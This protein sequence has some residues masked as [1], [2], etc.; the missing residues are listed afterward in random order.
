MSISEHN[1]AGSAAHS[2]R[3]LGGEIG[4]I[5]RVWVPLLFL[6]VTFYFGTQIA[7]GLCFI[8]PFGVRLNAAAVY[9]VLATTFLSWLLYRQRAWGRTRGGEPYSDAD[10]VV[11][12]VQIALWML[13]VGAGSLVLPI[14][15]Q[16]KPWSTWSLVFLYSGFAVTGFVKRKRLALAAKTQFE[17]I[18]IS[19]TRSRGMNTNS[20]GHES[21]TPEP[22]RPSPLD[23]AIPLDSA[24]AHV[25]GSDP[26]PE[27]GESGF[28]QEKFNG[29]SAESGGHL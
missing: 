11:A 21:T 15:L 27:F 13:L 22:D 25:W 2:R 24:T 26:T 14:A 17:R 3:G 9:A 6:V 18:R 1:A 10:R 28:G 8:G 7:V 4:V 20:I 5:L 19:R 12:F 16:L 29:H 23:P